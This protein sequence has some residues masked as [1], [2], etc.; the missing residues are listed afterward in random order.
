MEEIFTGKLAPITV[1]AYK[2]L[3][4]I[5]QLMD[6]L[7]KCEKAEE[8]IV[9]VFCDGAKSDKEI[10]LVNEVRDYVETVKRNNI[11]K[12]MQVIYQ[13]INKGLAHSIIEGVTEV[14]EKYGKIIVLEDDLLVS[15]DFIN[16]MNN[17]LDFYEKD[18]RYG[19]ISSYTMPIPYLRRYDKDVYVM[20]IADCWGWATWKDRWDNCD[21]E[22]ESLDSFKK[23]VNN[24]KRLEKLRAGMMNMLESQKAGIYDTWAARWFFHLYL[25]NQWTVYPREC[26]SINIGYD[27]TGTNCD[28]QTKFNNVLFSGNS[29]KFE[30]LK[31]DTKMEKKNAKYAK[32][33]QSFFVSIWKKIWMLAH[34]IKIAV[35]S[36]S[37]R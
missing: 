22:L 12:E 13:S 18:L 37:R 27:G 15:R 4:K 23:D 25:K 3:D 2:R 30:Y 35:K 17:A 29:C 33:K 21:W 1:F 5:K 16:Y 24:V 19:E 6:S 31:A 36:R 8:S 11:F 7:A 10:L 20:R 14:L 34:N 32:N 26:R 28:N 9:I